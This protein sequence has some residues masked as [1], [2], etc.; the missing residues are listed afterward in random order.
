MSINFHAIVLLPGLD[1]G[2][3]LYITEL[4]SK[5]LETDILPGS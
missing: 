4:G 2:G 5:D 1:L 3:G